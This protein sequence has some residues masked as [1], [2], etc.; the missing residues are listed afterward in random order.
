MSD[1]GDPIDGETVRTLAQHLAANVDIA[2]DG[3]LRLAW[4][5]PAGTAARDEARRQ[6][7]EA[8]DLAAG[9]RRIADE[10]DQR[11]HLGD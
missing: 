5:G 8:A 4:H 3:L 9:L 2:T 1:L 10:L 11:D 7:D 6:R